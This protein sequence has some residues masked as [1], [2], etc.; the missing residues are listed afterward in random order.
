MGHNSENEDD[1]FRKQQFYKLLGEYRTRMS[2]QAE[3]KGEIKTLYQRAGT[4]DIPKKAFAFAE[5]LRKDED[6]KIIAELEMQLWVAQTLGHPLG[7]QMSLF[8]D[9][10]PAE[11]RAYDEGYRAGALREPNRNPYEAGSKQGQ[12]WQAGHNDGNAFVNK[13]LEAAVN[14][15]EGDE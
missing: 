3:A 9:E 8:G 6:G 4:F 7:A 5:K 10:R 12:R 15:G 11:D 2:D 13:E 1:K 14:A